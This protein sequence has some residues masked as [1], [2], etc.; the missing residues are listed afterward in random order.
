MCW[1]YSGSNSK[2]AA[3]LNHLWSFIQDPEFDPTLHTSFSHDRK[4]KLIEKYLQD[5]SNPFKADHGWQTSS[6]PILLPKEKRKWKSELDTAI[7]T[8]TVDSVHHHDIIDIIISIFEDPIS[9]TSHMTP[10]KQYWK[11]SETQTVQVFGEAFSSPTCL[12]AYQEVNSLPRE[13]GDDLK[14]VAAPLMLWSDATHLANFGDASLWPVY[15]FFG[16]QSKYTR[17][18]P[19]A[20]ACHHIA[21]IPTISLI[22]LPN[23]FQDIYVG[24]FEEGSSD[25]VYTHCKRELMQAIWKLLLNKKFMH[26]YK[27]GIV[28][29]CSDEITQHVFL[30]FFSYSADYPEKILLACIK[31]LGKCPC[32]RCLVKKADIPDMGTES[33]MKTWEQQAQVDSDERI[34]KI[35]KA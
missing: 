29:R 30:R 9:S 16:N 19:T 1:Q 31:F 24:F 22:I 18:K 12:N 5:N 4:R 10:F 2:L 26:A 8:L 21:Y 28:I 25:D 34:K 11:I 13:Q 15:L 17:G 33:D 7:P 27:Y 14:R 32:P 6:V 3:E 20:A 23:N 35:L